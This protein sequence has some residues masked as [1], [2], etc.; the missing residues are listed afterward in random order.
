MALW[1][2]L[3]VPKAD[4]TNKGRQPG[5]KGLYDEECVRMKRVVS[6]A[7]VSRHDSCTSEEKFRACRTD[8]KKLLY[9]KTI[10]VE[11]REATAEN[12]SKKFW[13][14]ARLEKG[15]VNVV[16]T[17]IG[18]SVLVYHFST[19]YSTTTAGPLDST[20]VRDGLLPCQHVIEILNQ[21]VIIALC[22][23]KKKKAPGPDLVPLDLYREAPHYCAILLT[24][25]FN[26]ANGGN[27][28]PPSWHS[29]IIVQIYKKAVLPI[30]GQS[31]FL[32][33]PGNS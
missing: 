15:V 11:L 2:R 5:L 16:E 6:S 7:S 10:W 21:E 13:E 25:V 20:L 17:C 18:P 4:G 14:L 29:T 12:N 23:K 27:A 30:I 3:I 33:E 28:V 19:L 32:M 8:Y 9:Q 26:A 1:S 31:P 22:A 24:K